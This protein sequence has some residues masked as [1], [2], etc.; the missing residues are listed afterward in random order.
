MGPETF[1]LIADVLREVN[2]DILDFRSPEEVMEELQFRFECG[3]NASEP[4]FDVF[5]FR[6]RCRQPLRRKTNAT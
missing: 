5:T 1:E 2:N 6:S 3:L 4:S